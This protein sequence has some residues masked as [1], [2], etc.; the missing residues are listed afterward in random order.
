MQA[1]RSYQMGLSR[2]IEAMMR[3]HLCAAYPV[4]QDTPEQ[5]IRLLKLLDEVQN[6]KTQQEKTNR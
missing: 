3:A 5:F 1:Q 6:D 2:K 4:D